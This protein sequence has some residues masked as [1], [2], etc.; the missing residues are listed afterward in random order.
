MKTNRV[1]F[2]K[3][4]A[5]SLAVIIVGLAV[6]ATGRTAAYFTAEET[7]YNVITTGYLYMDLV[8][9]TA[10]GKPW[11]EEGMTGIVPGMSADKIAYVEN[12]GGVPF[13]T[14][15]SI[16]KLVLTADGKTEL[17]SEYITLDLNEEQWLEKDGYYYYHRILEPGEKTEP[18]FTKVMFGPELG[19]EYMTARVEIYVLA[20]AVQSAN[21]G[22]DPLEAMGW[23][24]S[25]KM[26]IESVQD[27]V[28]ADAA[29]QE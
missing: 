16:D 8:E 27:D 13:F 20:Q 25:G 29:E 2:W 10:D 4:A 9:E 1:K 14:R 22:D 12:K 24:A 7:A 5:L 26:F 6:I 28:A 17:S 15:I 19:N 3:K 21:N 11:P 23:S 18:L